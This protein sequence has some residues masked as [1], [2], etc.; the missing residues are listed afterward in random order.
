M[1]QL[2]VIRRTHCGQSSDQS[3]NLIEQWS[4][5]S[6]HVNK[7]MQWPNLMLINAKTIINHLHEQE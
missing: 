5:E 4:L 1:V 6:S 7:L 2:V 3:A